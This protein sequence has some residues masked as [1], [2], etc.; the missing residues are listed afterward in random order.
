MR[1]A[2]GA[3]AVRAGRSQ[4]VALPPG[5]HC[6]DGPA[7]RGVTHALRRCITMKYCRCQRQQTKQSLRPAG[8][9]RQA[10]NSS[11]W[12]HA[13]ARRSAPL[14][15]GLRAA[16]ALRVSGLSL[17][18]L[19][20]PCAADSSSGRPLQARRASA[21]PNS[22]RLKPKS[23]IGRRASRLR[24]YRQLPS[25]TCARCQR[26]H[27]SLPL[28]SRWRWSPLPR[29]GRPMG[30]T[31]KA[32]RT[33]CRK[34]CAAAS[35]A[36]ARS[37]LRNQPARPSCSPS[38]EASP[39][40]PAGR[41]ARP[42]FRCPLPRLLELRSRRLGHQPRARR[43]KTVNPLAL[44]RPGQPPERGPSSR[45]PACEAPRPGR[46]GVAQVG[47]RVAG[48]GAGGGGGAEAEHLPAGIFQPVGGVDG[49]AP[50]HPAQ[51]GQH[52]GCI[53]LGP[54]PSADLGECVL[55]EADAGAL[56][57]GWAHLCLVHGHQPL[58][59]HGLK[60]ACCGLPALGVA[61]NCGLGSLGHL[62]GLACR[63]GVGACSHQDAGLARLC[64]IAAAFEH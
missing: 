53:K 29:C 37:N 18:S 6:I 8:P 1:R 25:D 46:Q 59:R 38:H 54:R 20:A 17:R 39:A 21:W 33:P 32:P 10:S 28:R 5:Q 56:G 61:G 55:L 57:M 9:Q 47:G 30:Q 3:P 19:L 58:A 16:G 15:Q 26:Q 49:A 63:A 14:R 22:A 48:A 44:R 36:R 64:H 52:F 51:H 60:C 7:H 45:R 43:G 40:R 35:H 50:G 31:D 11:G 12:T 34:G 2:A 41:H 42:R 4:P 62:V 27:R 24:T 23:A 13:L